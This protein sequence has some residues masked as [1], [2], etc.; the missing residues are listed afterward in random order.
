MDSKQ[1]VLICGAGYVGAL[2]ARHLSD[3]GHEVCT[4]RRSDVAIP[5]V[6]H[7]VV[8]DVLTPA[9]LDQ[10]PF[11]PTWLVYALSPDE[12]SEVAYRRTYIAG[13]GAVLGHPGLNKQLRRVVLTSSTAVYGQKDGS[14]VTEN[15][16]TDPGAFNGTVLLEAEQLLE[17]RDAVCLRFGG[18]YG[19]GRTSLVDKIAHGELNLSAPGTRSGYTNRIHV[20]DCARAIVHVLTLSAPRSRYIAVDDDPAS[21]ETVV[22]FISGE[23]GVPYPASRPT[24]T[25][26]GKRCSNQALK[27]DGFQLSYPSFREGYRELIEARRQTLAG[28]RKG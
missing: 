28:A 25:T 14:W 1:Q 2:A 17:G 27:S 22:E 6:P 13:L 15:S 18:I 7:R 26:Q 4:I 3:G 16:A 12:R 10:V 9:T 19:P 21:F 23:L 24:S 20:V 8:G 5:G 11:E